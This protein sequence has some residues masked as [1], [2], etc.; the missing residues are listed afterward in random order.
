MLSVG[1]TKAHSNSM[2]TYCS[3]LPANSF[4]GPVFRQQTQ[5]V[6]DCTGQQVWI[7]VRLLRRIRYLDV[8]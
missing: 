1:K 6:P 4:K 3:A 5:S 7:G 8:T 2:R